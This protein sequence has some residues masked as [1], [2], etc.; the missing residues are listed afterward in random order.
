MPRTTTPSRGLSTATAESPAAARAL[1]GRDPGPAVRPG[2]PGRVSALVYVSGTGLGWAWRE[3]FE[4][5]ITARLAPHQRRISELRA[6]AAERELTILQ[7]SAE[8]N[9]G[10]D[11]AERMATPW[12]GINHD[13]YQQ[14]WTGLRR[15]WHETDLMPACL[16]FGIPVLILD[17]AADLRPRWAVD[18]LERALPNVTQVVLPGA[19]HLP[20][21]EVPAEFAS[22]LLSWLGVS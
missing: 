18:S 22:V 1:V 10:Q 4:R 15:T 5:N 21:L 9:D 12:F 6:A 19:G 14:I 20:S 3:P 7:W 17:G 11:R 16:S 8:F 13:S 2:P